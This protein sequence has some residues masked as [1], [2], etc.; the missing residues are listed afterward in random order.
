MPYPIRIA[1]LIGTL[2]ALSAISSVSA[3]PGPLAPAEM[4]QFATALQ[5]IGLTCADL[6]LPAEDI[7]L[8]G[9]DKY[10][11]NML[12]FLRA[13]V[14]RT[15]PYTRS[16]G[17]TLLANKDNLGMLVTSCHSRLDSAIRLGLV[18]DPLAAYR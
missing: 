3:A 14:L 15:G 1:V 7:G 13:D 4:Q 16:M 18:D 2:C 17:N 5:P 6:T 11:L 9:G 8:W 10:K 12:D